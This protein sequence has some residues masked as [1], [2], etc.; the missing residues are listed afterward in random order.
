M[1][2]SGRRASANDAPYEKTWVVTGGTRKS[3]KSD[4]LA[5]MPT[6]D[7]SDLTFVDESPQDERSNRR[8][9]VQSH[10]A[11]RQHRYRREAQSICSSSSSAS[12]IATPVRKDSSPE[13]HI[14]DGVA[15]IRLESPEFAKPHMPPPVVFV[16]LAHPPPLPLD[17]PGD[18]L[19]H[20]VQDLDI[21]MPQVL[22][23]E[24]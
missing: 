3:S 24:T 15:R 11:R 1:Q 2:Q 19:H 22:V 10:I 13:V 5:D 9:R 7:Y 20:H 8:R 14:E 12:T 21:S 17:D 4:P 23:S 18:A 6:M 16:D